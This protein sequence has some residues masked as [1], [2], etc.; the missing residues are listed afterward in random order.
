MRQDRSRRV[1]E[2]APR[3]FPRCEPGLMTLLQVAVCVGSLL[4]SMSASG[5]A[6]KSALVLNTPGQRATA[7]LIEHND[8]TY[9]VTA[10]HACAN[11]K[12][13]SVGSL[14][15]AQLD[16]KDI[17]ERIALFPSVDL[18]VIRCTP[19]GIKRI[20]AL[21]RRALR[22]DTR[23]PPIS[24]ISVDVVGNPTGNYMDRVNHPAWAY[25]AEYAAAFKRIPNLSTESPGYRTKILV[26]ASIHVSWGFSG[27][28]VC[29]GTGQDQRLVGIVQGGIP[30]TFTSWAI[31]AL[32]VQRCIDRYEEEK[33]VWPIQDW[34]PLGFPK[35]SYSAQTYC[36]CVSL[37]P[38]EF[39]ST[40]VGLD[41]R[42]GVEQRVRALFHL[43]L[44]GANTVGLRI[45][46]D[47]W[48]RVLSPPDPPK[49]IKQ[50]GNLVSFGWTVCLSREEKQMS[51]QVEV[52]T[53]GP[54]RD[55]YAT[56]PVTVRRPTRAEAWS[57]LALSPGRGDGHRVAASLER[58][59]ELGEDVV[60]W[61]TE[62]LGLEG[63]TLSQSRWSRVTVK[64]SRCAGCDL[65]GSAL[66]DVSFSEC[67]LTRSDLS[68]L[69][70]VSGLRFKNC[71]LRDAN[72]DEALTGCAEMT[73]S[74]AY[75]RELQ[76]AF[77]DA[78]KRV[79]RRLRLRIVAPVL[80][81]TSEQEGQSILRTLAQG[82][83]QT[84]PLYF[85]STRGRGRAEW[86]VD[87]LLEDME[88]AAAILR[89]QY[90]ERLVARPEILK[91]SLEL[92]W[93]KRDANGRPYRQNFDFTGP[94]RHKRSAQEIFM[95]ETLR[96]VAN[97]T[98]RIYDVTYQCL[99]GPGGWTYA[100]GSHR[101]K[102]E[103]G[104]SFRITSPV[105]FTW[106]RRFTSGTTVIRHTAHY[107][108]FRRVCRENC[109]G[110]PESSHIR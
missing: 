10:Y 56:L 68:D 74:Y 43:G 61:K 51:F 87:V 82:G 73:G 7:T 16:F 109:P 89:G 100:P 60:D 5:Q 91:H 42:L 72:L 54:S 50:G 83:L 2:E 35:N 3:T 18:A 31:P 76:L 69:R 39:G 75:L 14:H 40:D 67:D 65:S 6:A 98:A 47:S 66:R 46:P 15:P 22:L 63:R 78:W 110:W 32:A 34:P 62:T 88:K 11:A 64:R 90:G 13:L 37:H 102:G 105:T 92:R 104:A 95:S 86:V 55:L 84:P 94:N 45:K 58:L 38:S 12:A 96:G 44:P 85:R 28:P 79:A 9:V 59:A 70:I 30:R 77:G 108:V 103:Y 33:R 80:V 48:F 26:L 19:A 106:G 97:G 101:P 1:V 107:E 71:D 8:F 4:F 27:G 93:M 25:A 41:L 21:G 36:E 57:D 52:L 20:K 49:P 17:G 29:C 81:A 23:N 53:D 24:A 99:S